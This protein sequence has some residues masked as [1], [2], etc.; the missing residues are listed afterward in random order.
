V[1]EELAA[2][3]DGVAEA[4]ERAL[5]AVDR[6]RIARSD[7]SVSVTPEMVRSMTSA[8][9]PTITVTMIISIAVKPREPRACAAPDVPA[10]PVTSAV[11]MIFSWWC[12]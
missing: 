5:T 7:R 2:R 6:V 11:D 10:V 12:T 8:I 4:A 9:I 1:L 3:R